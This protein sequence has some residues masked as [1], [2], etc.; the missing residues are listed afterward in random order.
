MLGTAFLSQEAKAVSLNEDGT[1]QALLFPYYTVRST[2]G[3]PFNTFITIANH[4]A[5]AK[6]I[7]VRFREGRNSRE[8][9]SFNLFLSPNDVWAAAVVPTATGGRVISRD[10]SCV[11]PALTGAS[12]EVPGITFTSTAYVGDG[13]GDDLDRTREGWIEVLEMATLTGSSAAAV[14]HQLLTTRLPANCA[15]VQGSAALETAAPTGGLAGT[16]TLINVASGLDFTLN[17]VALADLASSAFYRPA[18]DAYPDFNA[19]EIVPA[20]IVIAN[21]FVYRST[22]SRGVDAVSAVLMRSAWLGEFILDAETASTTDFAVTFP[23]RHHYVAGGTAT[24]PFTASCQFP[25]T[26]AFAGEPIAMQVFNREEFGSGI[27]S[28]FNEF[29]P[30]ANFRCGAATVVDFHN[31]SAHTAFTAETLVLGSTNRGFIEAGM[32]RVVASNGWVGFTVTGGRTLTSLA[33]SSRTHV[34]T[35]V[36]TDGAHQFSGLPVIGFAAR[37]FINGTLTCSSG[38]CQGNYGGAFPLRYTRTISPSS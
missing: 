8:V 18:N 27:S 3:N 5:A 12:G 22:W 29:P 23:T 17:A 20:S 32:V 24:A 34:A 28:D 35:G 25:R 2:N 38:A 13:S 21:G 37:I 36:T 9:A 1:G 7:R 14:T 4:T 15:A 30:A 33:S 19:A 31:S 6:A 10:Q 26:D 16:L 11:S